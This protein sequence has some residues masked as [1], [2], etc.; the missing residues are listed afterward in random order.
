MDVE[1]ERFAMRLSIYMAE[2]VE[3]LE[4]RRS[5]EILASTWKLA[6]PLI[7]TGSLDLDAPLE[8]GITGKEY[9][10]A[11]TAIFGGTV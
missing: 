10:R 1:S 6:G 8:G 4:A 9:Y 3:L 11:G 7:H 2:K 5:L